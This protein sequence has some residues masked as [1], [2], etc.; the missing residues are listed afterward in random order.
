MNPQAHY[1]R[2]II[3]IVMV[4]FS[5]VAGLSYLHLK[6]SHQTITEADE[7]YITSMNNLHTKIEKLNRNFV[8]RQISKNTVLESVYIDTNKKNVVYNLIL[9]DISSADIDRLSKR[10]K[11]QIIQWEK[12][13]LIIKNKAD[14]HLTSLF[15]HGWSMVYIQKTND[16]SII[17]D[18]KISAN[19]IA[20]A[21][22]IDRSLAI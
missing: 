2:A 20:N 17:S 21:E 19:D 12:Q 4:L 5:V 9:L 18:I 15:A 13:G 8:G 11:Q 6:S 3:I 7:G 14:H 16:G 22:S 10:K 1:K